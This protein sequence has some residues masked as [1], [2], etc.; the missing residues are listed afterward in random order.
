M[1]YHRRVAS[2]L[3]SNYGSLVEV[4]W[5]EIDLFLD[6][7]PNGHLHHIVHLTNALLT[8]ASLR[9]TTA[10]EILKLFGVLILMSL[11]K[12]SNRRDLWATTPSNKYIPLQN[13]S[14]FIT[15][16]RFEAIRRHVRFSF[17]PS[18]EKDSE[19]PSSGWKHIDDFVEALNKHREENFT[20]S[21]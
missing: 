18:T 21:N 14:L 6:V 4:K 2:Q 13:F 5:R 12:F 3:M 17:Q 11:V 9:T 7:F 20:P 1:L 8:T 16:K 19:S 10:S 15:F